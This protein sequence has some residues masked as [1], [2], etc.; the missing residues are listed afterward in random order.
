MITTIL[1]NQK[2]TVKELKQLIETKGR[3]FISVPDADDLKF[4][5][6]QFGISCEWN[7]NICD[8][9]VFTKLSGWR[10]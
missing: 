5:E 8:Y 2:A 6:E 4:I 3:S 7:N 9:E 10:L 1:E